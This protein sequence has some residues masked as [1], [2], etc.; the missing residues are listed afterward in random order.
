[1]DKLYLIYYMLKQSMSRVLR[2]IFSFVLTIYFDDIAVT[3][4][5]YKAEEILFDLNILIDLELNADK[6]KAGLIEF[7]TDV[8]ALHLDVDAIARYCSQIVFRNIVETIYTKNK[9]NS[10]EAIT[11]QI[12]ENIDDINE[13]ARLNSY[14][15]YRFLSYLYIENL[16]QQV[17]SF[18]YYAPKLD[19][20][21]HVDALKQNVEGNSYYASTINSYLTVEEINDFK[22]YSNLNSYLSSAINYNLYV[23]SIN[24][25]VNSVYYA[26]IDISYNL[27]L[28]D[29]FGYSI[30]LSKYL[31]DSISYCLFIEDEV[32]YNV[33]LNKYSP[34]TSSFE[35]EMP[36]FKFDVTMG[37]MEVQPIYTSFI[38]LVESFDYSVD[39]K[40][41]EIIPL[42]TYTYLEDELLYY[43]NLNSSAPNYFNFTNDWSFYPNLT[44]DLN[45]Y[46]PISY[47]SILNYKVDFDFSIG[48][49]L[50]KLAKLIDY[51][52][53]E[54]TLGSMA[55]E[56]M[57]NLTYIYI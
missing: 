30:D 3:L 31:Y 56:S 49:L 19:Y 43:L 1:M 26:P 9:L 11:I 14:Y 8:E 2:I 35:Y 29:N 10:Y 50:F 45:K 48:M 32:Q 57:N 15:A 36:I 12:E 53:S 27:I 23:E 16:R 6:Y 37:V 13:Q 7:S 40:L 47:S 5:K 22:F 20:Y 38:L 55:N 42:D 44:L 52:G 25:D 17:R 51:N 41:K 28:S 33:I 4:N 39:I 46:L 54:Y 21:L 18:V 34:K 24:I